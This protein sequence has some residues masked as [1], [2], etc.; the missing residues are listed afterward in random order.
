MTSLT[1]G[2]RRTEGY[3][4]NSLHWAF[5]L[6]PMLALALGFR[7]AP[8]GLRIAFV[9]ATAIA[10]GAGLS[11]LHSALRD[12]DLLP[13][14]RWDA[15]R[16]PRRAAV[17]VV[18]AVAS[19]ASVVLVGRVGLPDLFTAVAIPGYLGGTLALP[20]LALPYAIGRPGRPILVGVVAIALSQVALWGNTTMTVEEIATRITAAYWAG[21]AAAAVVGFGQMFLNVLATTRELEHA[22]DEQ[23]RHAVTEERLRFSRDLHDV[24]GRTLSSV[25]LKAELAAAQAERGRP[26][27]V[28][29]MR[30]VQAI[31]T[32]AQEEVRAVVRGY[33]EADL[34]AE[35][36]GARALLESAGIRVSTTTAQ[37]LPAPVSRAFGWVVREAATN[38]LRHSDAADARLAVVRDERGATLTVTNDRPRPGRPDA[39]GSGLAGLAERLAEVGGRL[40]TDHSDGSFVLTATVDE[41]T[42]A[43]LEAAEETA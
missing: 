1:R 23:A 5:P 34:A 22:R 14:S 13:A 29:T 21:F 28:D 26:E 42:L 18:W 25:A 33:R 15:V 8:L 40:D 41:A 3:V 6:A 37:A 16:T 31:A 35:V 4:Y 39:V 9:V 7:P 10:A 32:A 24:F 11:A 38:I 27:A 19:V 2:V 36:A 20:L 17:L 30:E 43:R 12:A